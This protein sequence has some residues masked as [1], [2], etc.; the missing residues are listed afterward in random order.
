MGESPGVEDSSLE[1]FF[2]LL[3]KKIKQMTFVVALMSENMMRLEIKGQ[4]L[5]KGL[6]RLTAI[7]FGLSAAH[8]VEVR[9]IDNRQLQGAHPSGQLGVASIAKRGIVGLLA[10]APGYFFGFV[11]LLNH[12][13]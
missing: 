1:A 11:N 9:A 10:A 3:L 13:L 5:K 2:C 6:Q 8:P 12:R 7:D 4:L